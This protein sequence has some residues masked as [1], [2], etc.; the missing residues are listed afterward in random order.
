L[1]SPHLLEQRGDLLVI[2]M[3]DLHRNTFATPPINFRGSFT[4]RARQGIRS[5]SDRSP[6]D[7]N[8]G[9]LLSQNEG[10]PLSHAAAGARHDGDLA[11][12]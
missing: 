2:G 1:F 9:A 4:D 8:G 7:V 5:G 6:R 12:Q 3:V 10:N 11:S